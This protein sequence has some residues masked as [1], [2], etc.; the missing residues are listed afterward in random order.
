LAPLLAASE[1][2]VVC[3]RAEL[4]MPGA[5]IELSNAAGHLDTPGGKFRDLFL[6]MGAALQAGELA[7]ATDYADAAL[8][9]AQEH[10]LFHLAVPVNIALGSNLLASKREAEGLARYLDAQSL[11]Q[12]GS[13]Q[14]DEA[15]A[16][17]CKKL[18]LQVRVAHAAAVA[19]L[20]RFSDAASLFEQTVL[21]S[22][23]AGERVMALDAQRLTSFCHEQAG[24]KARAWQAA[25][26]ALEQAEALTTTEREHA[27]FG[28]FA[29][30][31]QR[32][33][34]AQPAHVANPVFAQLAALSRKEP[35]AEAQ[36]GAPAAH[37][38]P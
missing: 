16:N 12:A 33:A 3:Q 19:G 31:V 1:P 17:L 11:A 4:D 9:V 20:G 21:L 29:Q 27:N 28:A 35:M 23:A 37:G 24:D 26:L 6:R 13:E 15:L 8:V 2:C 5:M 32:M 7:R 18:H 36:P 34:A 30:A 10:A 22:A 38:S 25:L 14:A